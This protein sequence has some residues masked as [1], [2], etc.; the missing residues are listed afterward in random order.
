MRA[1]G[2]CPGHLTGF[3]FPCEHD[4]PL[5]S[6]SRGAGLCV[7]KGATSTVTVFEGR[8]EVVVT[9]NGREAAAPVTRSTVAWLMEGRPFDLTIDTVMT[10]P[11]SAGF[12]MSAAGALS[13]AFA[14][15]EALELPPE[16]AFEAAH[17]AELGH[18]TGLG[19]V[20]ALTRGGMTFRK[21]EGLPP[22]GQV[23]RI[24][25]R[26]DIIAAVVGEGM[27]TANVLGNEEQRFRI[28]QAGRECYMSLCREPTVDNFFRQSRQFTEMIGIATP[29]IMRALR[30]VDAFGHGS[31]IM[32]GNAVFATGDVDAIDRALQAYGPTYRLSL[33][34]KGP[35]VL[36]VEF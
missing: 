22:Y 7:D 23:D 18:R 13:A 27:H 29:R 11:V 5:R 28:D 8:G 15:A 14:L 4:D 9:I 2:F 19:D 17:R 10:L 24:T 33:D 31:M 1:I 35:R 12:G 34:T 21:K 16:K 26:L 36:D 20:P 6:G 3:F 30:D 25:D 32:L